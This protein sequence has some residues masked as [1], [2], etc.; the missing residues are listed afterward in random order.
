MICQCV[1]PCEQLLDQS[2]P[3][4]EQLTQTRRGAPTQRGVTHT[5]RDSEVFPAPCW[6]QSAA[7]GV[8]R[9]KKRLPEEV[10]TTGGRGHC[11]QPPDSHPSPSLTHWVDV[12]SAWDRWLYSL[13]GP[14]P[15][16]L[17]MLPN[18]PDTLTRSKFRALSRSPIAASVGVYPPW[19]F[20]WGG[21][22]L[23]S[24]SWSL[25]HSPTSL[26]CILTRIG[27][28]EWFHN[29]LGE[30][31]AAVIGVWRAGECRRESVGGI[32]GLC[33]GEGSVIGAGRGVGPPPAHR[34]SQSPTTAQ[35]CSD[36]LTDSPYQSHQTSDTPIHGINTPQLFGSTQSVLKWRATVALDFVII[37]LNEFV[38]WTHSCSNEDRICSFLLVGPPHTRT[39]EECPF[40]EPGWLRGRYKVS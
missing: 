37:L 27:N 30:W 20:T 6:S 35:I 38:R 15:D 39:T 25:F 29:L 23:E 8:P 28:R 5:Q 24:E 4:K 13:P 40:S 36:L 26:W 19:G 17:P 18:P 2:L 9:Y 7:P 21:I 34:D 1:P 14:A 11:L 22:W 31:R 16:N 12:G 3:F 10:R 32:R 33:R